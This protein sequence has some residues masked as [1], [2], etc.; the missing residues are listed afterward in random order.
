MHASTR[1]LRVKSET[2]V[3]CS[4]WLCKLWLRR[5]TMRWS[6]VQ[7]AGSRQARAVYRR[8]AVGKVGNK[9]GRG[10]WLGGVNCECLVLQVM[11][12]D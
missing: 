10:K 9:E 8:Q 1:C 5:N 6:S 4:K 2:S 12:T 3:G 7:E 11:V